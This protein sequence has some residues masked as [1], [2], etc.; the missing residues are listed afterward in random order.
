MVEKVIWADE[1]V[2]DLREIF[3]FIALESD[4][5]AR[6]VA[7]EIVEAGES[8]ITFPE[9]G[10]VVYD[11][12]GKRYRALNVREYRIIYRTGVYA[13]EVSR[14]FHGK[15]RLTPKMDT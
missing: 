5:A 13:V 8:L 6:K 4:V 7:L 10:R 11:S 9:R 14:I 1:A 3:E 2:D 12:E 15:R